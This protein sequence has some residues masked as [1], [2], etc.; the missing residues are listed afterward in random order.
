[1]GLHPEYC[2][3]PASEE[4]INDPTNP[5][6]YWRFRFHVPLEDLVHNQPLVSELHDMILRTNH[7]I[8]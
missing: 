4:V 2:K 8:F 6:H 3:R 7:S 5:R 1:M